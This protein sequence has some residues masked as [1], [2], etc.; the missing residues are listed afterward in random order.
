MRF[1]KHGE[2]VCLNGCSCFFKS[3][4]CHKNKVIYHPTIRNPLYSKHQAYLSL[5]NATGYHTD[6]KC[7]HA[8]AKR[9]D[10]AEHRFSLHH[11]CLEQSSRVLR[12]TPLPATSCH[13][14]TNPSFDEQCPFTLHPKP[15]INIK[16]SID[17]GS[18]DFSERGV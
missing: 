15:S 13:D 14:Y 9:L 5:K 11:G 2:Q 16:N 1:P 3:I 4:V 7:C 6:A 8:G 17:N 10:Y 12:M 18:I